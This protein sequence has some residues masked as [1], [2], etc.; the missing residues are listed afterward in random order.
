MLAPLSQ[1]DSRELLMAAIPE[2]KAYTFSAPVS[3]LTFFSKY[4]TVGFVILE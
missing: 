3:S 4:I 1:S 2:L